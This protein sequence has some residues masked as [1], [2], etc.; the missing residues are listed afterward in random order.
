MVSHDMPPA[1]PMTSP[2]SAVGLGR[3]GVMGQSDESQGRP[4]VYGE[5]RDLHLVNCAWSLLRVCR[6][7]CVRVGARIPR[8]FRGEED[9]LT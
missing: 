2:G 6:K 5:A 7:V 8:C 1:P 3:F 4:S 9:D